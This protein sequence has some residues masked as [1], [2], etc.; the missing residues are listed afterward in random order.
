MSHRKSIKFQSF[1]NE[2]SEN[3]KQLI[4]GGRDLFFK[5]CLGI[6]K[7][8]Q[9]RN[10]DEEVDDVAKHLSVNH[11]KFY[12]LRRIRRRFLNRVSSAKEQG[13]ILNLWLLVASATW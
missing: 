8:V 2:L 4:K 3:L 10:D 1:V 6:V 12:W 11:Q 9:I 13:S 7:S 5:I